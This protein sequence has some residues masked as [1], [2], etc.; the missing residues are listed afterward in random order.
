VPNQ[1]V[2]TCTR[3]HATQIV[4]RHGTGSTL[5]TGQGRTICRP[6]FKKH[7]EY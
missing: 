7:A 2:E 3:V 4:T 6:F 5:I 1:T